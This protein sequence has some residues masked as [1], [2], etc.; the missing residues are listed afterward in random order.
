MQK[1]M[2]PLAIILLASL[3]PALQGQDRRE[4]AHRP[5]EY[6][7]SVTVELSTEL[8]APKDGSS[9]ISNPIVRRLSS[10]SNVADLQ[11]TGTL[12]GGVI[13]VTFGFRTVQAF[14]E[15]NDSAAT[16]ELLEELKK[17]S[18]GGVKVGLTMN[19]AAIGK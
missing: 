3:A 7:H 14:N 1:Y 11:I 2:L 5:L 9:I 17:L 12:T 6:Q 16:R 18:P 19:P 10:I 4:W 13:K 15:W 8:Q